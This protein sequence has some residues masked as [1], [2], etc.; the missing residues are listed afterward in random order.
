MSKKNKQLE[1]SSWQSGMQITSAQQHDEKVELMASEL[2]SNNTPKQLAV[3]TAQHII[4]T[5][6][7][8]NA[9]EAQGEVTQLEIL[10]NEILLKRTAQIAKIVL[11][12]FKTKT[13]QSK[14][15]GLSILN[16]GKAT[17]RKRAKEIASGLWNKDTEQKIRLGQMADLVWKVLVDE[18]YTNYLPN[19]AASIKAWIKPVAPTYACKGGRPKT[20]I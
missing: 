20:T 18:D 2:L 19:T 5:D 10:K 12:A 9:Q 7:L 14:M 3:I 1:L 13:N 6:M 16:E 11:E 17:A 8:V 15:S 4:Y